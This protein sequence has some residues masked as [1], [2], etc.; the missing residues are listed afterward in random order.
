MKELNACFL[1]RK[2]DEYDTDM[3]KTDPILKNK[4]KVPIKERLTWES[5]GQVSTVFTSEEFKDNNGIK[6]V[7][8]LIERKSENDLVDFESAALILT[9]FLRNKVDVSSQ[10]YM[11]ILDMVYWQLEKEGTAMLTQFDGRNIAYFL[12][13]L[14][15]LKKMG[16]NEE[17]LKELFDYFGGVLLGKGIGSRI[18]KE[19][20]RVLLRIFEGSEK[21]FGHPKEI[22]EFLKVHQPKE[23]TRKKGESW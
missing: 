7:V 10:V 19:D 22:M 16:I 13:S 15:E 14:K 17:L 6:R 1:N 5:V 11:K 12:N 20:Y 2:L 8:E 9:N 23:E 4:F 3:D 18:E 21:E